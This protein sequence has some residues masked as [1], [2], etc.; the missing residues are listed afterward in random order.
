MTEEVKHRSV[1]QYNQYQLC[2]YS[3]YL[4]RIARVWSRPAAWLPQGTAFHEVVDQVAKSKGSMSLEDAQALFS[5]EYDKDIGEMCRD[6]P[7]VTFWSRSGPYGG[8][9]DIER[10]YNVGLEQI[11][12]FFAWHEKHQEER[13]WTTPT[14]DV[15]TE[16]AFDID[17]DGVPVKGF[18]DAVLDVVED[19]D[20][21]EFSSVLRVR[22]YKTGKAPSDDFQLGVYRVALLLMFGI[23]VQEGDFWLGKSGKATFP[24]DLSDWTVERVTEMF[25]ELEA[26][27]QAENFEPAP[28]PSKCRFCDV[29][30]SCQFSMG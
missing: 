10:R 1:S 25:H 6:T 14:G 22:D 27:I 8:K 16:I 19:D 21:E 23:D 5:S 2:P 9:V 18:I 17:L 12:K 4:A 28:E 11:E 20:P 29:S 26:N 15:G 30:A 3:Y 24:Y 13:F 7:N